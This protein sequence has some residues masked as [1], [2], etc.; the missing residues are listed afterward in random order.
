MQC[1][2]CLL[3]NT[4]LFLVPTWLSDLC[5]LQMLFLLC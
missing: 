3:I 2:I 4:L 5:F 1:L